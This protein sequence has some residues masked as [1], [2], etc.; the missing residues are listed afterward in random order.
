MPFNRGDK[1]TSM[2]F[3][4]DDTSQHTHMPFNLRNTPATLSRAL[5]NIVSEV[6]WEMCLFNID[7]TAN[8]S[9]YECHHVKDIDE[10][11]T[12]SPV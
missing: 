1:N 6:Q 3:S 2:F 11:L 10:V 4:H 12:I 5:N 8:F 9:K 7:D